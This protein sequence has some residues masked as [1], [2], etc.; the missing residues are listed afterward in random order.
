M[1]FFVIACLTSCINDKEE[2]NISPI[3]EDNQGALTF[4]SSLNPFDDAGVMHNYYSRDIMDNTGFTDNSQPLSVRLDMLEDYYR[5]EHNGS[6][7]LD[8]LIGSD[9]ELVDLSYASHPV[10][11]QSEKDFL[12][13][14]FTRTGSFDWSQKNPISNWHDMMNDVVRNGLN[15]SFQ[16]EKLVM[17]TVS[18]AQHSGVLWYDVLIEGEDEV[19]I[20]QA[21]YWCIAAAVL[22][23]AS[24]LIASA[25]DGFDEL[26]AGDFFSAAGASVETYFS[27]P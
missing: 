24:S 11:T 16:N 23:D 4:R 27:C 8:F 20:Q 14:T 26:E 6:V 17:S 3:T 12:D 5:N 25:S 15:S 9:G 13:V 1:F 22:S 21:N 19:T 18:I 10:L 7:N 2:A